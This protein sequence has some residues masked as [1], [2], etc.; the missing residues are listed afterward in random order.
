MEVAN[1][2]VNGLAEILANPDPR[3]KDWMWLSTP[4]PTAIA[5]T[6]YVAIVLAGPKVM[7]NREP[8]SLKNFSIAYNF[9]MVL[10][11]AYMCYELMVSAYLLN[12]S[13]T[14]QPLDLTDGPVQRRMASALWWYYFSKFIEFTD[15]VCNRNVALVM[16]AMWFSFTSSLPPRSL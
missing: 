1:N 5:C 4:W 13:M 3:T 10:L 15:T 7:A 16:S 8:F 14:C 9:S 2:F 12:F 6:A 11:S